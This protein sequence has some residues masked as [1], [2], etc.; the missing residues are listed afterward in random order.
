MKDKLKLGTP[1]VLLQ[2]H[3]Q[4]ILV[5]NNE[6]CL[7]INVH[8]TKY[9]FMYCKHNLGENLKHKY[10]QNILEIRQM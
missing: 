6:I 9:V 4:V 2:E 8:S 10:I 5:A 3:F 7:K 1:Y